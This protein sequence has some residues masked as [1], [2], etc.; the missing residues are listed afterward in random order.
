[1][2]DMQ[3][4]VPAAATAVHG[5][6][7]S[8]RGVISLLADLLVRGH[9]LAAGATLDSLLH[10]E[11]EGSTAFGGGVAIPHGRV[12]QMAGVHGAFLRLANPVDWG[13]PDDQPVDLVVG[14]VGPDGTE[15]LKSLA[16]VSRAL[17]DVGLV[18]RLRG[19]DDADLLWSL[20]AGQAAP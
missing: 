3:H 11:A 17:R 1:M 8:K 7:L 4:L 16:L 10:R 19:A 6:I 14:L 9:G 15:L 12:G 20:L 2:T 5:G 13:A 18:A